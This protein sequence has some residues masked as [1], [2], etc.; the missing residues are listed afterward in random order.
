MHFYTLL[1]YIDHCHLSKVVHRDLKLENIL[2]SEEKNILISDFGLGR[3]YQVSCCC[4]FKIYIYIYIDILVGKISTKFLNNNHIKLI[5]NNSFP[6]LSFPFF[7]F[8]C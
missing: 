2:L 3:V 4:C 8:F 5:L 7:F 6:F 1:S